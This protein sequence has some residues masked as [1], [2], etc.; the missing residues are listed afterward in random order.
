MSKYYK[1]PES[2]KPGFYALF[3]TTYPKLAFSY[4][5]VVFLLRGKQITRDI[6]NVRAGYGGGIEVTFMWI[7]PIPFKY[8]SHIIFR[9]ND[10]Y[11]RFV[12]EISKKI[13]SKKDHL[14]IKLNC[15]LFFCNKVKVAFKYENESIEYVLKNKLKV[16]RDIYLY[17]G[18]PYDTFFHFLKQ[19]GL[20]R[21]MGDPYY[22][23]SARAGA[24]I[25]GNEKK[26]EEFLKRFAK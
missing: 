10:D 20:G 12:R 16:H 1:L 7:K 5:P 17:T 21:K 22:V 2:L 24:Y 11:Y 15:T 25:L 14:Y 19:G 4:G 23:T 6:P 18:H 26:I 8:V 9:I 3:T 13:I